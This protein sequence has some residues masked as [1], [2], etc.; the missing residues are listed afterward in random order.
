VTVRKRINN[1]QT[2]VMRI[3]CMGAVENIGK[4]EATVSLNDGHVSDRAIHHARADGCS[5]SPPTQIH[6]TKTHMCQTGTCQ[7]VLHPHQPDARCGGS[8]SHFAVGAAF[9]QVSLVGVTIRRPTG[10][11]R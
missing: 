8:S 3:D 10:P 9:D 5:S 6:G 11:S 7:A 4:A 2:G 1:P